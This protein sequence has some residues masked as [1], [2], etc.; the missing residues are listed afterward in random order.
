[1]TRVLP[2]LAAAWI[3]LVGAYGLATS[4]NLVRSVGCLAVCQIGRAHV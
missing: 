1:M 4:R 2:Y 3:F